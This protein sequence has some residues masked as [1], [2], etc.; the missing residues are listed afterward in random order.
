MVCYGCIATKCIQY[1]S[2]ISNMFDDVIMK[3]WISAVG[4]SPG[5]V[6]QLM[7]SVD[8]AMTLGSTVTCGHFSLSPSSTLSLT[9]SSEQPDNEYELNQFLSWC[10]KVTWVH[11]NAHNALNMPRK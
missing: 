4:I 6:N 3:S 10:H 7:G 9:H 8:G 1:S 11:K 5:V 2:W